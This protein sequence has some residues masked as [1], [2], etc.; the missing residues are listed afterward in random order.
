[1]RRPLELSPLKSQFFWFSL[2]LASGL[3]VISSSLIAQ[4]QEQSSSKDASAVHAVDL[5]VVPSSGE[6]RKDSSLGT[7]FQINSDQLS[8]SSN[9]KKIKQ[10]TAR[11]TDHSHSIIWHVLDNFGVPMLFSGNGP[12]FDPSLS[13][14]DKARREHSSGAGSREA[15]DLRQSL[16]GNAM[17]PAAVQ[18]ESK[19][20]R[21]ELEGT[22]FETGTDGKEKANSR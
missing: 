14:R 15:N 11:T 3:F 10:R 8:S 9:D 19:I 4:G 21:S 20:P 7:F 17:S 16:P 2:F 5:N 13:S 1:M 18:S 22:V 6:S 12:L